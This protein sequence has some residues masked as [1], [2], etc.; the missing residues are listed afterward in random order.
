MAARLGSPT[1]ARFTIHGGAN[2]EAQDYAGDT[3]LHVA[4]QTD[5]EDMVQLLL[6][7]GASE[8]AANI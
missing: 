6:E 2:I 3:P 4:V 7:E 8:G 1:F 5:R